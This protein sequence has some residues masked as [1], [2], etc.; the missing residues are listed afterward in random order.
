MLRRAAVTLLALGLTFAWSGAVL[1]QGKAAAPR[2]TPI[3]ISGTVDQVVAAGAGAGRRRR[4]CRGP[5]A[6]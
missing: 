3:K 4:L 5:A 6:A 2:T 1:A